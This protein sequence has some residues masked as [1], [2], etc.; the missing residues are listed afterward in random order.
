MSSPLPT[1]SPQRGRQRHPAGDQPPIQLTDLLT[2]GKA[3]GRSIDIK[4]EIT[5]PSTSAQTTS[6]TL[7]SNMELGERACRSLPDSPELTNFINSGF[8]L[9]EDDHTTTDLATAHYEIN[10]FCSSTASPSASSNS[11][12]SLPSVF[13]SSEEL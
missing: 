8:K 3:I 1:E 2:K 11:Q 6:N 10:Q 5:L 13:T 4:T 9:L 7:S 12:G